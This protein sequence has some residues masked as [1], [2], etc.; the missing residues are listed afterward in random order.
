MQT[1]DFGEIHGNNF[2]VAPRKP[3]VPQPQPG[4]AGSS[5][6]ARVRAPW[7]PTADFNRTYAVDGQIGARATTPNSPAGRPRPRRRASPAATTV[8]ASAVPT[9]S[10]FW[11][12][13]AGYAEIGEDFN[14]GGRFPQPLRLPAAQRLR[15]PSVSARRRGSCQGVRGPASTTTASGTST[16]FN[17][18]QRYSIGGEVEFRSGAQ[19]SFSGGGRYEGLVDSFLI[20]EGVEIEAGRY[21]DYGIF[22]FM[23]T[24][25]G[26]AGQSVRNVSRPAVSLAGDQLAINP[27][28]SIRLGDYLTSEISWSYNDIEVAG[29]A[30]KAN[31]GRLRVTSRLQHEAADPGSGPVQR[32]DG[33]GVDE[34]ALQLAERGEQRPLPGLQRDLRVRATGP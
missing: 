9:G 31:L 19:I 8:S 28:L 13:R 3:R 33:Q 5:S 21:D 25:R 10:P 22:L 23:N 17:Q 12:W 32:H 30:F 26:R 14:P 27:A 7:R 1:D 16:V 24:N 15:S 6:T 20:R 2:S 29:G 34:P 11:R 18:T 4:R